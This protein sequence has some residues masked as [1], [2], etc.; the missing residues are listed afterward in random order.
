MSDNDTLS[1]LKDAS[2]ESLRSALIEI[3][4]LHG[5]SEVDVKNYI[6]GVPTVDLQKV[7]EALHLAF[8]KIDHSD[9]DMPTG[10]DFYVESS[11]DAPWILKEH[12]K[13]LDKARTICKELNERPFNVLSAIQAAYKSMSGLTLLT[14]AFVMAEIEVEQ[15]RY[16]PY[17]L[18]IIKI[19]SGEE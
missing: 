6:E 13:W 15:K 3:A 9:I 2:P 18:S 14:E 16:N 11:C 7:A 12:K 10:C 8:C 19:L 1:W 4:R 17:K 5:M